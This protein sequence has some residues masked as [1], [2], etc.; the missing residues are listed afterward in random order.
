MPLSRRKR[1]WKKVLRGWTAGAIEQRPF[2]NW[3]DFILNI[4]GL[5]LWLNWRAGKADP[6]GRR[7]PATLAGTVRR[8]EPLR[9]RRWTFPVILAAFLVMRAVLYWLIGPALGWVGTLNLGV[10]SPAFRSTWFGPM[11][12]F[13]ILSFALTLGILYSWLIL[14]SLLKGPKPV[15]DF[16][17][18]QLGY[19]DGW[20]VSVKLLSP[21]IVAAVSWWLLS[22]ALAWLRV[23]PRPVSEAVRIG[24][25]VI[26]G[27]QCYLVWTFPVA[28]LLFLYLLNNYIYFGAQPI[29]KYVDVVGQKLLRPLKGVP[30]RVGKADFAPVVGIALV[31]LVAT[32]AG[33]G[34]G[35]L[36]ARL[37]FLKH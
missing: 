17:R 16:V 23:V 12:V 26:L 7:T 29:W 31:F 27:A 30:L 9:L 11:L 14:L 36:Y 2:M 35:F 6:M 15:H 22:W 10:I 37:A 21:P 24:E 13:S 28:A 32:F 8:A 5:L 1:L 18:L 19:I 4:A 33:R 34:L 20:S 3:V 25:S